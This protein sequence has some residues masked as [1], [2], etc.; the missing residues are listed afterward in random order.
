[1]VDYATLVF[2]FEFSPV[3]AVNCDNQKIMGKENDTQ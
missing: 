1:M 3:A 2:L